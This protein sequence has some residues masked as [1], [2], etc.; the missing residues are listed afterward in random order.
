MGI[1]TI[2][3]SGLTLLH[4]DITKNMKYDRQTRAILKKVLHEESNT[5][6]VGCHKGEILDLLLKHAP[7]G[8]HFGFE[9]IPYM[10]QNL[11]DKYRSRATIYPYALSDKEGLTTFNFVKNAPAYSGI[12]QRRYDISN[13][14]IEQIEVPLKP[15]DAIIPETLKIDLIKIDVEGAELGVLNGGKK[16]ILKHQPTVIFEFGKGASDVYGTKPEDIY[17]LLVDEA[18]LSLFT[19]KGYLSKQSPLGLGAFKDL[20]DR[21]K[22]YY[23]LARK[24]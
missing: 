7:S 14:E 2:I 1:K 21:Q 8:C 15:L 3:K 24:A 18:K 5:V 17:T 11:K 12:K 4:L 19:L 9:P 10:Y 16:L 23:F 22:E 13:P 6:D 20:Y